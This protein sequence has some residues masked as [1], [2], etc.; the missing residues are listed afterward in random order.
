[1][2]IYLPNAYCMPQTVPNALQLILPTI[3]WDFQNYTNLPQRLKHT[4]QEHI[5]VTNRVLNEI[6]N[7]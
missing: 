2:T 6:Q 3:P 7:Y 4:A 1:M 5:E